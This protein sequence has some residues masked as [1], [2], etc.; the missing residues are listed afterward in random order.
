MLFRSKGEITFHKDTRQGSTS[1]RDK[2]KYASKNREVVHDGVV[3]YI[4]P[5]PMKAVFNLTNGLKAAK[6]AEKPPSDKQVSRNRPRNSWDKREY[7]PLGEP[8]DVVYKTLLQHKLITPLDNPRPFDPHPRPSWWKETAYCEY[9]QNKVHNTLNC[10]HLHNKIQDLIDDGEL[11]VDGHN[12][13]AD[14][15]A[16][17]EPFP[18]Y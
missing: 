17:K 6:Q 18:T 12:K 14:H 5:K 1:A 11:V 3:D 8:L 2:S 15:K 9:H 16:F 13:N 10:Y 4:T 7:T